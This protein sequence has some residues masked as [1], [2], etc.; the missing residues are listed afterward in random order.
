M[1]LFLHDALHRLLLFERDEAE[2][3]SFV[4]FV[5]HGEFDRL[6]LF[7]STAQN[8]IQPF[9]RKGKTRDELQTNPSTFSYLSE[10][11]KVLSDFLLGRVWREAAHKD[12]LHGL[13]ALH[14]LGFFG[15]DDLSVEFVFLL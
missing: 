15:V 11:T 10:G 12:L 9:L 6:H 13:L 2:A 1:V 4:C 3:S 8:N 7:T 14:G 5:L